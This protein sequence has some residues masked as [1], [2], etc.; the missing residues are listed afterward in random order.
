MF[1]SA[2]DAGPSGRC[3]PMESRPPRFE[4]LQFSI[5]NSPRSE[6]TPLLYT[7]Q[8]FEKNV[9]DTRECVGGS[10]SPPPTRGS[11]YQPETWTPGSGRSPTYTEVKVLRGTRPSETTGRIPTANPTG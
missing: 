6:N 4:R 7:R 11:K 5:A 8:N 9:A 1:I 3:P 2:N 10:K